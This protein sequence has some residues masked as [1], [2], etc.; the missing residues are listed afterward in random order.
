MHVQ[1]KD[2]KRPE[3]VVRA[4]IATNDRPNAELV[5]KISRP[6]AAV[7]VPNMLCLE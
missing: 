1:M 2:N 7:L 4:R 3:E 5:E 6:R